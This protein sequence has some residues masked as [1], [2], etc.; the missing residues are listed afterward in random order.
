MIAML[1]VDFVCCGVWRRLVYLS[2]IPCKP[3]NYL[4]VF[5]TSK[6]GILVSHPD[7]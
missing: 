4:P 2:Y 5:E 1:D 7:I 3:C 6:V